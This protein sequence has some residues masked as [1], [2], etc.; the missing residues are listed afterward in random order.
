MD[1]L[2]S[3][4]GAQATD[5]PLPSHSALGYSRRSCPL[6]TQFKWNELA[7]EKY[8]SAHPKSPAT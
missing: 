4:Y 7:S 2:L 1:Y 3:P 5:N 6:G 8:C